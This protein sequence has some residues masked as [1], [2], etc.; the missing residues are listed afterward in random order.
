MYF[1]YLLG[2]KN[3]TLELEKD[4][5]LMFLALDGDIDFYPK[6]LTTCLSHLQQNRELGFC[7]GQIHPQG[8]GMN[9][10]LYY[11]RFEYAIGH[12]FQKATEQ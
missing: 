5:E 12:W 8:S 2:Y 11:Q 1:N 6:A 7:C 9:P 4:Y 10:L 3:Q